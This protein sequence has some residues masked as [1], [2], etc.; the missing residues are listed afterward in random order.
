MAVYVDNLAVA[1]DD[2]QAFMD[3]LTKTYKFKLKGTGEISFHLG[4]DFFRDPDGTL[5]M[6]PKKYIDKVAEGYERM[7]GEKPNQLYRS[8][9][10][11]GDHPET[12]T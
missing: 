5:C 6:Q 7:F 4:C 10:A 11:K 8:P 1:T 9:L 3:E 12:D 2:P